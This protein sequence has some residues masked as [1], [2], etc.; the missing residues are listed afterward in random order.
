MKIRKNQISND[1]MSKKK[2]KRKKKK[3]EDIVL[4]FIEMRMVGY[5]Q[6]LEAYP[7]ATGSLGSRIRRHSIFI[8]VVLEKLNPLIIKVETRQINFSVHVSLSGTRDKL[9]GL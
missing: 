6:L 3:R 9:C 5:T 4:L 1:H 8:Q 2:K 7:D